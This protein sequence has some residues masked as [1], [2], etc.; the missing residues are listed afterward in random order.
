MKAWWKNS[1][2]YV[3][4][5]SAVLIV[6]E[7]FTDFRIIGLFGL[8]FLLLSL[9]LFVKKEWL[10]KLMILVGLFLVLLTI[11]LTR[12]FWLLVLTIIFA[13]IL[14]QSEGIHEMGNLSDSI[15]HPRLDEPSNYY[16]I[17]LVQPQSSQRTILEHTSLFDMR[18]QRRTTYEWNDINIVYFGGN[19]IIDLGNTVVPVGE[20][21][22]MIRQFFGLT[23]L[24]IPRDI[25]LAL[26]ISLVT[27]RVI[28]ESQAYDLTLDNFKWR[29]PDYNQA[30]RKLKLVVSSVIGDVEVIIL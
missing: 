28:F 18:D 19:S 11:I 30:S 5:L 23:R 24:I 4:L 15:L 26:N 6:V 17:Q 12:S 20:H 3:M 8:G 14:F 13:L 21:V 7:I 22:V 16:G 29:S 10:N 1:I 9:S 2:F 27:G 25:G